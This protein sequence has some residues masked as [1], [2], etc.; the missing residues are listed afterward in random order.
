MTLFSIFFLVVTASVLRRM[1]W[2]IASRTIGFVSVVLFL[3]IGCGLL[4]NIALGSLQRDFVTDT[5]ITW[6]EQ[7]IIVLLGEG[8]SI[9]SSA[10]E[11]SP[12]AYAGIAKTA[13]LYHACKQTANECKIIVSGGD[14]LNLG[15]SEAEIYSAHLMQLGIAKN[16]LLLE[17]DS[18][19]TWENAR[20]TAALLQQKTFT[21]TIL[22]T[23]AIHLKRSLLYF[24]HFD[25]SPIPIRSNYLSTSVSWVPTSYSFLLIDTALH[26]YIGIMR[27]YIYIFFDWN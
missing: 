1:R 13:A 26:E 23:S 12:L 20:N 4:N 24:S 3:V 17:K 9:S 11:P 16:D 25:L 27:Y 14:P 19:N 22:V 21:Q 5:P 10:I 2:I 6:K 18:K 7:N 15:I 8:T